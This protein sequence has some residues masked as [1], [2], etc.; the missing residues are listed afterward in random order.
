MSLPKEFAI[1]AVFGECFAIYD[2]YMWFVVPRVETAAMQRK[3]P[4]VLSQ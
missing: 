1:Q 3:P 4:L 2:R